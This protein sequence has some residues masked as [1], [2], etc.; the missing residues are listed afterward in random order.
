VL[1][2]VDTFFGV[3]TERRHAI[4]D[5][6]ANGKVADAWAKFLDDPHRLETED[7][8]KGRYLP[9]VIDSSSVIGVDVVHPDG[10]MTQ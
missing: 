1:Y 4:N 10:S 6:I 9:R 7:T 5:P 3:S 8:R 2:G